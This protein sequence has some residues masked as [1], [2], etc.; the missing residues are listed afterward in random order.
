MAS[1]LVAGDK[2][3]Y[4]SINRPSIQTINII[5]WGLIPDPGTHFW[6]EA[7]RSISSLFPLEMLW[8]G[9]HF[10]KNLPSYDPA[11]GRI[12]NI[13]TGYLSFPPRE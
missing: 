9:L 7:G 4:G 6:N 10:Q 5:F 11:P 12:R 3:E 2:Q 8:S 13:P 1:G